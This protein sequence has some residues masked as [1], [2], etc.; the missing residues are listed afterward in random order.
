MSKVNILIPRSRLDAPLYSKI[1]RTT[2][3]K[4][5]MS[6]FRSADSVSPFVR[7]LCSQRAST[8]AHVPDVIWGRDSITCAPWTED[9]AAAVTSDPLCR[10]LST[11]D[12]KARSHLSTPHWCY[13]SVV[14]QAQHGHSRQR[15]F[16][17]RCSR[18]MRPCSFCHWL[19]L[20][21]KAI[22][23]KHILTQR[24]SLEG[25]EENWQRRLESAWYACVMASI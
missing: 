12:F 23:P 17:W 24:A 14:L 25:L 20:V 19:Q 10:L 22:L 15:A 3:Q 8:P 11:A 9:T 1:L 2:C 7:S 4:D 13:S 5:W 16:P 6:L 18:L 21:R